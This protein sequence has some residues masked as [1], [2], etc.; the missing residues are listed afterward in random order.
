MGIDGIQGY[1]YVKSSIP[2][3]S[4]NAATSIG[5]NQGWLSDHRLFYCNFMSVYNRLSL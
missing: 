4:T 3:G 1:S 2:V 5:R